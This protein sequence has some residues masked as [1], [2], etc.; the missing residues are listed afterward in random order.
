MAWQRRSATFGWAIILAGFVAIAITLAAPAAAQDRLS[1]TIPLNEYQNSGVSGTATL[2]GAGR[3][4]HVEMMLS[5]EPL[6]GNHP[7]H[8]HTG[9]C[10]DF[11]PDPTYPLTTV[12]LDDVSDAGISETTVED[13][14]LRDL[15]DSD[16][17]I[18][19]H[20]SAE[21]LTNYFVCGDIK[22]SSTATPTVT[23]IVTDT[24]R[25]GVGSAQLDLSWTTLFG[26][27]AVLFAV[28]SVALAS[29]RGAR[30]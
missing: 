10:A 28:A 24:P 12:I 3:A 17:V 14:R 29:K 8:I 7:T 11:D 16:Y 15:L 9:T 6:T 4:T 22:M 18:L 2:E 19:V 5:G 26:L 27:L 1:I 23:D 30:G 20:K 25:A 13:V 21:E